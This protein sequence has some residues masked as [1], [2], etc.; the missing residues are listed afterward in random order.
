MSNYEMLFIID[1]SLSDDQ[2]NEIIKKVEALIEKNGG[3][4]ANVDRWGTKKF[5]YP[6]NYKNEG[7]YVLLNFESDAAAPKA[8]ASVMNITEGIVRQMIVAK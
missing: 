2:K 5:A 6:I 7:F 3:K 8:I 4:V 1:G